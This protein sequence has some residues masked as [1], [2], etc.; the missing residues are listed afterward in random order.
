MKEEQKAWQFNLEYMSWWNYKNATLGRVGQDWDT[1]K[2][3][4]LI[5]G[6][7]NFALNFLYV[8]PDFLIEF[9]DIQKS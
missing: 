8:A 5:I 1:L 6:G 9:L 4:D 2:R 7:I 3:A